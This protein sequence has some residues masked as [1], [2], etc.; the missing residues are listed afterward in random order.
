MYY[1][2]QVIYM[3][4]YALL[5]LVSTFI[6][7][8]V[9]VVFFRSS[10]YM[11][12][13]TSLIFIAALVIVLPDIRKLVPQRSSTESSGEGGNVFSELVR[14]AM[15]KLDKK[16][17]VAAYTPVGAVGAV[18]AGPAESAEDSALL[19]KQMQQ[20]NAEGE[21]HVL[22]KLAA[23]IPPT[24]KR[25]RSKARAALPEV[26]PAQAQNDAATAST[27]PS[28]VQN[29]VSSNASMS[30]GAAASGHTLS[31]WNASFARMKHM[32]TSRLSSSAS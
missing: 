7:S 30:S 22:S 2:V 17:Q 14:Q 23:M 20:I 27:S 11:E 3:L 1:S 6:K 32:V 15:S 31:K 26:P 19:Y 12:I 5:M 9:S 13:C 21:H 8:C 18:G 10:G 16:Q 24:E 29:T 28:E 4:M 25:K